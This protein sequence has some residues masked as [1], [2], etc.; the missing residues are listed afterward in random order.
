MFV[1]TTLRALSIMACLL[2]LPAAAFA[3]EKTEMKECMAMVHS[4]NADIDFIENMIPHH[5]M[6][7]DM[8]KKEL[9]SGNDD[10][11]RAM[12]KKI[13]ADQQAE[14]SKMQAWLKNKKQEGK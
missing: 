11:A 6:A 14:I 5:Q 12:A 13:I 3:H 9:E 8:A 4:G 1:K 2:M 10:E 7:I